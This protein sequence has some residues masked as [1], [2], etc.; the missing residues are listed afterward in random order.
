MIQRPQVGIR[1]REAV[2]VR[3]QPGHEGHR[4]RRV[5]AECGRGRQECRR[6][7]R[8]IREAARQAGGWDHGNQ[9]ERPCDIH[10]PWKAVY[11]QSLNARAW[12]HKTNR[13]AIQC[14]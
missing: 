12:L 7:S 10:R 11:S 1:E 3:R 14:Y 8:P 5:R 9:S 4:H 2:Y 6:V 13:V